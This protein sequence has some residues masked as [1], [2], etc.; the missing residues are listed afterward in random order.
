M[1]SVVSGEKGVPF[2]VPSPEKVHTG[3]TLENKKADEELAMAMAKGD[4][5][6]ANQL[7]RQ[8]FGFGL[9]REWN[10][11]VEVK[12]CVKDGENGVR[13]CVNPEEKPDFYRLFLGQKN[14][15]QQWVADFDRAF[16]AVR[17][18][19]RLHR[20]HLRQQE[21]QKSK[22]FAFS[23]E[24]P[25]LSQVEKEPCTKKTVRYREKEKDLSLSM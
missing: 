2:V 1:Q 13:L 20:I 19:T 11:F 14:G 21:I 16:D 18:G 15:A 23:P 6:R 5:T 7:G 12:N 9:M 10:G 3:A 25:S 24:K 17:T 4:W 22:Q 8:L